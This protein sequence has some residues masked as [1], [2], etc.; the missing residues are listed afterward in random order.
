MW[1]VASWMSQAT[2]VSSTGS[3]QASLRSHGELSFYLLFHLEDV[4]LALAMRLEILL[5]GT[6]LCCGLSV[7]SNL[8][9]GRPVAMAQLLWKMP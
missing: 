2:S 8:C 5:G 3:P 7:L 9:G 4:P 1:N 6:N